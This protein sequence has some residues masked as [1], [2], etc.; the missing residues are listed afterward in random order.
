MNRPTDADCPDPDKNDRE[1]ELWIR[2]RDGSRR[3]NPERATDP[4][5]SLAR[6]A[7]V[8]EPPDGETT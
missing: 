6:G 1:Y 8:K 7:P 5:K 4:T 2:N 3:E